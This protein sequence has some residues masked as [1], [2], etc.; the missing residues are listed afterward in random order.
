M[1]TQKQA[2]I[3][4][5]PLIIWRSGTSRTHRAA[6]ISEHGVRTV[7]TGR[8]YWS[9][10]FSFCAQVCPFVPPRSSQSAHGT[11]FSASS[12]RLSQVQLYVVYSTRCASLEKLLRSNRAQRYRWHRSCC[13]GGCAAWVLRTAHL[14]DQWQSLWARGR[15]HCGGRRGRS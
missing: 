8:W 2:S 7:R 12:M 6:A 5:F 10:K 4:T 14:G 9:E 11:C 1:H 13:S 15:I 3:F